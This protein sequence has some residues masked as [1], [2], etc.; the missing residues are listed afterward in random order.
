M[1]A[2]NSIVS[3]TIVD[4]RL[5]YRATIT[6]N[7]LASSIPIGSLKHMGSHQLQPWT[8]A[9]DQ[10]SPDPDPKPLP[11]WNYG[12]EPAGARPNS[13]RRSESGKADSP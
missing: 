7:P 1:H 8:R 4:P 9:F 5:G 6:D 10:A 12:A 11:W 2:G 13:A 3:L